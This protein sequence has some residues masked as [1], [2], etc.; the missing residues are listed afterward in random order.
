MENLNSDVIPVGSGSTS[1]GKKFYVNDDFF[2]DMTSV[3]YWVLGIFAS[4]GCV[5]RNHAKLCQSGDAGLMVIRYIKNLI[6]SE[7]PIYVRTLDVGKPVY[8]ICFSSSKMIDIFRKYGIVQNK[9][10][11]YSLPNIPD[12]YLPSFLAGYVEGDGCITISKYKRATNLLSASFVGT[13]EFVEACAKRIPISGK[14]RKHSLSEI[15]EIRWYSKKAIQFCEWLYSDK[16]L[17]HS[18]KYDNYLAGKELYA[19]TRYVRFGEIKEHM[20]QDF[21]SGLVSTGKECAEKYGLREQT[22]FRW[23]KGWR[24]QGVINRDYHIITKEI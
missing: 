15:Y 24:E 20:I 12:E 21:N 1:K 19:T 8:S 4:D 23:L 7:S 3:Q 22:V 13:K 14:V 2:D 18:Y 10:K 16:E 6:Q 5:W 11:T 17:Y 9:T